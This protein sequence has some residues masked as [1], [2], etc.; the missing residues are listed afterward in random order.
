MKRRWDKKKTNPSE[1]P[2]RNPKPHD[3]AAEK[4]RPILGLIFTPDLDRRR[5]GAA[6]GRAR[7]SI[8]ETH[9]WSHTRIPPF[10]GPKFWRECLASP[11]NPMEGVT[12]RRS[13]KPARPTHCWV[14]GARISNSER[15]KNGRGPRISLINDACLLTVRACTQIPRPF[16]FSVLATHYAVLHS[17]LQS[18]SF[19]S[20]DKF[21]WTLLQPYLPLPFSCTL[22][23]RVRSGVLQILHRPPVLLAAVAIVCSTCRRRLPQVHFSEILKF[24]LCLFFSSA[25]IPPTVFSTASVLLSSTR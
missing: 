19:L 16:F 11:R 14:V 4:T 18:P 3:S 23:V 5:R 25:K 17:A 22:S 8:P 6:L 1:M 9:H 10:Q 13:S 21:H 15:T 20:P 24:I 2:N 7:P 12:T